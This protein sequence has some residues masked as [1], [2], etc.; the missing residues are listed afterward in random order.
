MYLESDNTLHLLML[1]DIHDIRTWF[2]IKKWKAYISR[3]QYSFITTDNPVSEIFPQRTSL[4]GAHI[5][6]RTHY[7][8]I[9]PDILIE[10]TKPMGNRKIKRESILPSNERKI[11]GLNLICAKQ[12]EQY[13]YS[14]SKGELD[15]IMS[16]VT[17]TH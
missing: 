8:A 6:E 3:G 4:Y 9:A 7:L 2:F 16:N 15:A 14:K 13:V 12:A 5:C 1:K 17:T 11:L 10:L